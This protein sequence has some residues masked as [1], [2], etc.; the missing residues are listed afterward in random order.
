M[1]LE[2][3]GEVGR[4]SCR[5]AEGFCFFSQEQWQA[6]NLCKQK[7]HHQRCVPKHSPIRLGGVSPGVCVGHSCCCGVTSCC[8]VH[9]IPPLSLGLPASSWVCLLPWD[10]PDQP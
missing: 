2:G 4:S 9:G 5:L 3:A 6:A 7:G 8:C 1:A 10:K